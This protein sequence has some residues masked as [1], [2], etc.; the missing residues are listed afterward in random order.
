[1]RLIL[2]GRMKCCSR[3]NFQILALRTRLKFKGEGNDG[4]VNEE[5]DVVLSSKPKVWR[6]YERKKKK[7]NVGV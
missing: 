6:V 3:I 5:T 7:G 4:P 2:H 1:M